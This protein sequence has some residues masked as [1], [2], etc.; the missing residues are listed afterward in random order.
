MTPLRTLA[1]TFAAA[2]VLVALLPATASA[3]AAYPV[4]CGATTNLFTYVA[5]HCTV[6]GAGATGTL[7]ACPDFVDCFSRYWCTAEV[8][9]ITLACNFPFL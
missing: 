5:Y 7:N 4:S 6:Y 1:P 9:P 2:L 3:D 8:S